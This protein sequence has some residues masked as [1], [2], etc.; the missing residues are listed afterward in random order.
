MLAIAIASQIIILTRMNSVI[1]FYVI[2]IGFETYL[3]IKMI[4][5]LRM[6][7]V[8]IKISEDGISQKGV[9]SSKEKIFSWENIKRFKFK[10]VKS[11]MGRSLKVY[12]LEDKKG[13]K[14]VFN[15]LFYKS[16]EL[17]EL[18]KSKVK[19]RDWS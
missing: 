11:G 13:D 3:L 15:T 5:L 18:I 7:L 2:M 14:I 19:L 10:F 16:E 8:K 6:Y 4:S 12:V 9:T 1:W 17:V